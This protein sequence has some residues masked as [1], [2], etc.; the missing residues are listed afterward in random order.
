MAGSCWQDPIMAAGLL[1]PFTLLKHTACL[2]PGIMLNDPGPL[3]APCIAQD[4][5]GGNSK[6]CLVIAISDAIEH[7]S[8]AFDSLKFGKPEFELQIWPAAAPDRFVAWKCY[9]KCTLYMIGSQQAQ[10][11]SSFFPP[12]VLRNH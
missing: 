3:K 8:A 4:S 2:Q 12:F 1:C 10:S 5:L 9:F 11:P 7:A 6:A